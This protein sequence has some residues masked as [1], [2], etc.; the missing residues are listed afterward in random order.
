MIAIIAGALLLAAFGPTL[1]AEF[2]T[3]F[4]LEEFDSSMTESFGDHR[5]VVSYSY[6]RAQIYAYSDGENGADC[7]GGI[8][9]LKREGESWEICGWEPMWS[10][11]DGNHRVPWA[12]WWHARYFLF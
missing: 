10:K 2:L 6:D 1:H 11:D 7:L 8:V 5:K 3:A 12:Y 4:H 9:E